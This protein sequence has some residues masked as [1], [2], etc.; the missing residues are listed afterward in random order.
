MSHGHLKTTEVKMNF[1]QVPMKWMV[2]LALWAGLSLAWAAP[3][4]FEIDKDHFSVGFLVDH[5][6]YAQQLG[7]FLEGSG[8]FVYDPISDE[9]V[10]GEVVI[11]ADSVFTNHRRRDGHLKGRDFFNARAHGEIRFVATTWDPASGILSGDL[12][13]LGQTHP[14]QLEASVNK[15]ED[16]PFGH[17]KPTLGVSIRATINR[18]QWGMTYGI[19]QTMVGDGVALLIELEA[20]AD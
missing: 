17:K 9:L 13:M 2:A 12:T 7:Q 1:I 3:Q 19:E 11:E 4:R 5:I 6:G 15:L 14:V 10:S 20:I 16:Y 8:S 18:S